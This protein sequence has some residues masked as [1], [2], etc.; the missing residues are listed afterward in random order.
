M[1]EPLQISDAIAAVLPDLPDE[2][3]KTVEDTLK[4]PGAVTT[5]R[6][7]ASIEAHT[8][9]KTGCRLGPKG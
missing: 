3:V 7:A 8:S 5:A 1:A 2:V 4:T 9:Q 6:F